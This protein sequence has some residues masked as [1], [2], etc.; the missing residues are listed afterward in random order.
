[1][2]TERSIAVVHSG[3]AINAGTA[4]IIPDSLGLGNIW[5]LITVIN[6]TDQDIK[7]SFTNTNGSAHAFIVTQSIKGFSKSFKIPID[8]ATIKVNSTSAVAAA[9]GKITFN[10]GS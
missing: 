5:K 9:V 4:V 10:L 6:D 2:C 8:N 1:M 7:V 3:A